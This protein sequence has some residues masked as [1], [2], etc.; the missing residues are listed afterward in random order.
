MNI[1]SLT[2]VAGARVRI[3]QPYT[4]D[5]RP[6]VAHWS[7]SASCAS[8]GD[9]R[10]FFPEIGESAGVAKAVC[11]GC[12]VRRECL[13]EAIKVEGVELGEYHRHGVYGGLAPR[14][15]VALIRSGW[16]PGDPLPA[17]VGATGPLRTCPDCGLRF[18]NLDRHRRQKHPGVAA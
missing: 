18:H 11:V 17:V 10:L 4:P 12:P 8:V 3:A 14:E 7:V 1:A 9:D 6:V 15:R 5:T 13:D 16:R 2:D